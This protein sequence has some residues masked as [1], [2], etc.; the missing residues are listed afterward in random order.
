MEVAKPVEGQKM[1]LG[2]GVPLLWGPLQPKRIGVFEPE[3]KVL[4]NLIDAFQYLKE[5]YNG[6]GEGFKQPGL[7][8]DERLEL[9]GFQKYLPSQAFLCLYDTHSIPA[10][11]SWR[12]KRQAK[13]YNLCI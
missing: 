2:A 11:T 12:W 4:R 8:E 5:V 1:L 7:V 10:E 6:A 9:N 13:E 3:E